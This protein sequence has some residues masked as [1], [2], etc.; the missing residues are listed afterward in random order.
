MQKN[1]EKWMDRLEAQLN[2]SS[3]DESEDESEQSNAVEEETNQREETIVSHLTPA[4]TM[5]FI[6]FSLHLVM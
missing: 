1:P 5:Y 3:E 4:N 2:D 6:S